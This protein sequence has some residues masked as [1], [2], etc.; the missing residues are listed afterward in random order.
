MMLLDEK[1]YEG[2]YNKTKRGVQLQIDSNF[3]YY[4]YQ[5]VM[6]GILSTVLKTVQ[7]KKISLYN[8]VFLNTV[9]KAVF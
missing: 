7:F 3:Y 9:L 1:D 8:V 6:P 4:V 5:V 2:H